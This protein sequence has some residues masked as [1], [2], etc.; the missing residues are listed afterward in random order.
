MPAE[1]KR[2]L[3]RLCGVMLGLLTCAE[4]AQAELLRVGPGQAYAT[5]CAAFAA[6]LAG[7]TIELDASA[8]YVGDVCTITAHRLTIRGVGGRAH[9]NAGGKSAGGKAIWVIQGDDTVIEDVELSGCRVPDKN[10][11]GIRQEG[12]NLTVRRGYFHDNENGLLGN[13]DHDSVY[14]IEDSEFARNGAGDGQSHNLYIGEIGHFT[15]RGSYSHHAK[16]GHLVKSRALRNDILYNRLSDED[17]GASY[18][19]DLPQGGRSLVI[20]NVFQKSQAAQNGAFVSYAREATKNPDSALWVVG[21]TFFNGR[22]AGTFV[23]VDESVGPVTLRNNIFAGPGVVC[24]QTSAL[25]EA[26]LVGEAA[27]ADAARYDFALSAGSR[28]IDQGVPPG[29]ALGASLAPACQYQHPAHAVVRRV[30][31]ALDRGAFEL[32]GE[33]MRACGQPEPPAADAGRPGLLDGAVAASPSDAERPE[34]R[35]DAALPADAGR[36]PAAADDR[37]NGC[38]THAG[39]SP[40][41]VWLVL[42]ALLVRRAGAST[43]ARSYT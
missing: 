42:L 5:P 4:V 14:L 1:M 25:A 34:P 13:A 20:G 33:S 7:D 16:V 37:D 24:D 26:N 23:A 8:P 27:F 19:L 22:S 30:V 3:G 11:A 36:S 28:A 21:N 41:A 12:R 38:R 32:G 6:S 35:V 18:Q 39:G 29:L 2:L 10:G 17:G 31:G 43:K 15:L 40:S 9:I